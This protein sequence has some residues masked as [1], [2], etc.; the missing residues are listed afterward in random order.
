MQT[1]TF[2][3]EAGYLGALASHG[4]FWAA[5]NVAGQAFL[6]DPFRGGLLYFRFL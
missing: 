6:L 5:G 4:A 3:T 1:I 2:Q